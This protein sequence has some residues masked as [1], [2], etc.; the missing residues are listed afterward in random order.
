MRNGRWDGNAIAMGN[1]GGDGQWWRQWVTSGVTMGDSNSG[2]T[3][4]MAVNGSGAM[5]GRT[6]ATAQ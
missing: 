4:L 2:S 5:D 1:G 3:N 6:A